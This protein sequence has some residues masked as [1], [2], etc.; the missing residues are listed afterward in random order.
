MWQETPIP[1][2]LEFHMFNWTNPHLVEKDRNVKPAFVEMG[3]Y[4]FYEHHIREN[5]TFHDNDTL[6]YLNKRTWRFEPTLSN[7]S[8]DDVITILNPIAVVSCKNIIYLVVFLYG[9]KV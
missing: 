2:Y 3:P 5:I 6:T 1:M 7:G 8:L 4:T 9:Y